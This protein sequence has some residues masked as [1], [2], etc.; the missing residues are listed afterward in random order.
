MDPRIRINKQRDAFTLIELLVV[1]AIIAVLASLILPA[2]GSAKAKAK[3]TGCLS[4]LRQQ[5]LAWQ[6]Y[7][8]ENDSKF[9]DARM[10]KSRLPGGYKPWDGWPFSDPRS[11]W[12]LELMQAEIRSGQIWTCPSVVNSQ[13]M[14]FPSSFQKISED[15]SGPISTYWMW[16]FDR[17]DDP[18]PLD[19]FWGKSQSQVM[20]DLVKANNKFIGLPSGPS[21]VELVVDIYYPGTIDPVETALK[22]RAAHFD[23][24]NRLMLD[25]HVQFRKDKRT[26][27][28]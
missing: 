8:N 14:K 27:K 26:G 13:M 16:R 15:P 5:G 3:R 20:G 6:I 25:G 19:N 23:G 2:L 24:K 18:I 21:Q 4:N 9:P 10:S 1:I 28:K 11:G 12:A 17:I 22:G 7:L